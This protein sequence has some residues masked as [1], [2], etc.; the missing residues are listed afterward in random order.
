MRKIKIKARNILLIL[1]IVGASLFV[2]ASKLDY[3][4]RKS[5][6]LNLKAENFFEY[7]KIREKY[8]DE[9]YNNK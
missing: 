1:I 7:K 4:D 5:S 9:D 8:N 2:I 3:N 6:R